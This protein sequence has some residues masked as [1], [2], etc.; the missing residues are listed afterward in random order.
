MRRIYHFFLPLLFSFIFL[1]CN[2]DEQ[3][4]ES[5][6]KS[7]F[8]SGNL[9]GFHDG[10][11]FYLYNLETNSNIDSA[12]VE[13]GKFLMK[14]QIARPPVSFW[15][16]TNDEKDQVYTPLF[17]GNDSVFIK[18]DKEDFTWNVKTTGSIIDSN[19]RQL[20]QSTKELDI[21][22]DSIIFAHHAKPNF[23]KKKAQDG[24][25]E[26]ISKIDKSIER[27][28]INAIK[29]PNNTYAHLLMLSRLKDKIPK[30]SVQLIFDSYK[31]DLKQSKYGRVIKLYLE[32]DHILKGDPYL[33]FEGINQYG[34]N[35][36]LTKVRKKNKFLLINYT[37]AYCGH[38]ISASDE[39][40]KINED[41]K[42]QLSIVSYSAD[43]K[44]EDWLNSVKRDSNLWP[45][46]W[47]G[48]GKF[49]KS[50]IRYNFSM[51]PT[52]LL[53]DL[54]GKIVDR[55]IGYNEGELKNDLKNYL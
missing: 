34:E 10:I 12:L 9:T 20:M 53:I 37:S 32:S 24:F 39:L 23:E 30:D 28:E 5:T 36:S 50:A 43:P 21:K 31:D 15:L 35:T 25:L 8:I 54:E 2:K 16:N 33:N 4:I 49:S 14:G 40:K 3:K 45:S 51:T 26:S 22:R 13:D 55:W 7:Y 42:E 18:A 29:N 6:S 46:I 44:K 52:F 48:Q 11:K 19:Y 17:I 47:N 27:K 1:G 38:C 41:Y